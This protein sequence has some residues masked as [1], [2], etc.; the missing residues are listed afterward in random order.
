MFILEQVLKNYKQYDVLIY[1]DA[2][3]VMGDLGWII[4]TKTN[5]RRRYRRL[6]PSR[7]PSIAATTVAELTLP[8]IHVPICLFFNIQITKHCYRAPRLSI[9]N[10]IH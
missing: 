2:D 6:L 10:T 5:S 8:S 1:A 3:V 7:L 9:M 4:A